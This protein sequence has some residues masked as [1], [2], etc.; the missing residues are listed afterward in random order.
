M[1]KSEIKITNK[2]FKKIVRSINSE[3]KL[4]SVKLLDLGIVNPLYKLTIDSNDYIL[5]ICNPLFESWKLDKEVLAL[6]ILEERTNIPVPNTVHVDTSK[7]IIPFKFFVMEKLDGVNLYKNYSKLSFGH[8]KKVFT[9][10]GNYLTQMHSIKFNRFGDIVKDNNT[11]RIVAMKEIY[12]ESKKIN[13]GPYGK[14]SNQFSAFVENHWKGVKKG[15]LK[16]HGKVLYDYIQ[17]NL[18]L[19]DVNVKPCFAHGDYGMH[20]ILVNNKGV[21]GIVDLELSHAGCAEYDYSRAKNDFFGVFS[22]L[23]EKRE[24]QQKFLKSYKIKKI[25]AYYKRRKIYEAFYYLNTVNAY[26]W[27]IKGMTK[28]QANKFTQK[29]KTAVESFKK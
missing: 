27:I 24:L 10:L 23:K 13:P 4:S 6:R 16:K 28:Q 18:N 22:P 29:L 20:N 15:S 12:S 8:L 1:H 3:R 5:K 17:N 14:W 26:P 9:Q 21:S 25:P 11:T 2:E 7:K 19:I